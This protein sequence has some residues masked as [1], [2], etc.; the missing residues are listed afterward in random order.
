MCGRDVCS[1][2]E[3]MCVA[4]REMR[5]RGRREADPRE[6]WTESSLSFTFF[7][8][9]IEICKASLVHGVQLG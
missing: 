8:V 3:T 5:G 4:G 7:I 9:E 6:S 1:A 2:G